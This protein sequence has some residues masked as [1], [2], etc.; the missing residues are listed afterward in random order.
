MLN[1][2]QILHYLMWISSSL[3]LWFCC[4]ILLMLFSYFYCIFVKFGDSQPFIEL[5]YS[6]LNSLFLVL[7]F[8]HSP[9]LPL[10]SSLIHNRGP[11]Q[12]G[13]DR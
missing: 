11:E 2:I 10:F 7:V 3:I 8:M 5:I 9:D 4:C 1:K 13:M 6:L 12:L